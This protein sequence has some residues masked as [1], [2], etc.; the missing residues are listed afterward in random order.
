MKCKRKS[1]GEYG[2]VVEYLT[3]MPEILTSILNIRV[4]N[5]FDTLKMKNRHAK[6]FIFNF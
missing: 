3:I 6:S 4:D 5:V 1:I 2:S